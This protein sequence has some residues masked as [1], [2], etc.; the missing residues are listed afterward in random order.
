MLLKVLP[1]EL[2]FHIFRYLDAKSVSNLFLV[3][4]NWKVYASHEILWR[5]LLLRN[6]FF[7]I[8]DE[9]DLEVKLPR[10]LPLKTIRVSDIIANINSLNTRE[11]ES[12]TLE[13]LKDR[14]TERLLQE[15]KNENLN[16]SNSEKK[17]I[18]VDEWI[19]KDNIEFF[20]E[21]CELT[22]L[23]ELEPSQIIGEG[24]YASSEDHESQSINETLELGNTFWS[25]KGSADEFSFEF[26]RY[27]LVQPICVIS[28]IELIP[29]KAA[30]QPG[31]PIY[32]PKYISV[33]VSFT[34]N[35]NDFHYTSELFAVKNIN[36][37]Q[38]FNIKPVFVIG[39]YL[40]INLFGRNTRQPADQLY[41]TVLQSVKALGLPIGCF[42]NL[43]TVA[44]SC[45]E[46]SN[47]LN[48]KWEGKFQ[49]FQNGGVDN[50]IKHLE[51]FFRPF[52]S[53][54][55][56]QNNLKSELKNELRNGNWKYVAR[57]IAAADE[58]VESEFR[59]QKYLTWFEKNAKLIIENKQEQ[60]TSSEDEEE[61]QECQLKVFIG[62][63]SNTF[64]EPILYYLKFLI[65]NGHTLTQ[66][67]A[68]RLALYSIKKNSYQVFY[69]CLINE[70]FSSTEELGDLF[71]SIYLTLAL[72]IYT[73]AMVVDKMIDCS[74]QLKRYNGAVHLLSLGLNIQE[75]EVAMKKVYQFHSSFVE[76]V[77]FSVYAMRQN[78]SPILRTT[79]M[80]SLGVA[81]E[82]LHL[83][84][85][86]LE[87][88]IFG[89]AEQ[90]E[91]ASPNT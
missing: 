2:I 82:T 27:K 39:G 57:R 64:T 9:E 74:L 54:R 46:L 90:K 42:L 36:K 56:G 68:E 78:N 4:K 22:K 45:I 59:S 11:E 10:I 58:G 20:K 72:D 77:K 34:P 53:S 44:K 5:E 6:S 43:K 81:E 25:S 19:L 3:S 70:K 13:L 41:Y 14:A 28:Q 29:F 12:N 75:F 18:F 23:V 49:S 31:G 8:I 50:N 33:S 69:N 40:Q 15:P 88:Y 7:K 86:E 67:E 48:C 26:L 1:D 47:K 89:W 17:N 38:T 62:P 73:R 80:E 63:Q 85:W 30:F 87:R 66:Y 79:L 51:R 65:K 60:E 84:D 16:V 24:I 83:P 37:V 35:G 91:N 71:R 55:E 61:E 32:A 76:M 21:T 52:M